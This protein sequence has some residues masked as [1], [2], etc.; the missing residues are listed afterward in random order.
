MA[1]SGV[2]MSCQ[3]VTLDIR[4]TF[5]LWSMDSGAVDEQ[6][7]ITASD[8]TVTS[9]SMLNE[10]TEAGGA[11]QHWLGCTGLCFQAWPRGGVHTDNMLIAD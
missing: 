1:T 2:T 10:S 8:R 9:T 4:H 5:L 3:R 11:Q 7:G 6:L